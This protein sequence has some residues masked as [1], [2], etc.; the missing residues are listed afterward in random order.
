MPFIVPE[1]RIEDFQYQI[2]STG[3]R[4]EHARPVLEEIMDKI[5]ERNADAFATR[6]ATTGRYWAPLRAST[7]KRKENY[8]QLFWS[9][10]DPLVRGGAL[11]QSLSFRDADHQILE[12]DDDSLYLAT[13]LDYAAL[14]VTGTSRMPSRPPMTIAAKHAREYVG[15]LNDFI[16]GEREGNA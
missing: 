1:D 7:I 8:P 12:V 13:T 9:A 4:A 16:F 11:Y 5:L 6:G 14:H 15:M 10:G 3:E 2:N